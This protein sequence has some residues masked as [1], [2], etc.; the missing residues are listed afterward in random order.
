MK[1]S[2]CCL[3]R[4]AAR[5]MRLAGTQPARIPLAACCRRRMGKV[6]PDF[7]P[8]PKKLSPFELFSGKAHRELHEAAFGRVN[9]L[10]DEQVAL[11]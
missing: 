8:V 7:Y 4:L 1:S 11:Q 6:S 9:D 5:T 2:Q 10:A 3:S